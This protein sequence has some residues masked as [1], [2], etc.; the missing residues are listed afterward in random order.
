MA[1]DEFNNCDFNNCMK[2][3]ENNLTDFC[4]YLSV[5]LL[6]QLAGILLH[7]SKIGF[8]TI[9]APQTVHDTIIFQSA[10]DISENGININN[11]SVRTT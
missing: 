1:D 8:L 5:V 2:H 6:Q 7:L 4:L 10:A 11:A 3:K 9:A